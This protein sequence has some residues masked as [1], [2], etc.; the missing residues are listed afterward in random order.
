MGTSKFRAVLVFEGACVV[1]RNKMQHSETKYV[2]LNLNEG[3]VYRNAIRKL[4]YGIVVI[5]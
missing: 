4:L 5:F 3:N 1:G 2:V